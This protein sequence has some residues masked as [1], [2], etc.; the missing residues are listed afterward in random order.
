MTLKQTGSGC[1]LVLSMLLV[2]L[3]AAPTMAQRNKDLPPNSGAEQSGEAKQKQGNGAVGPRK[4][5][6]NQGPDSN[7]RKRGQQGGQNMS[8]RQR[9][10][11]L[12]E[13]FKK[14]DADGDGILLKS[15][16]PQRMQKR[17]DQIDGN[18]DGQLD[19]Q[20]VG[21]LIRQMRE[22]AEQMTGDRKPGQAGNPPG[23]GTDGKTKR[24]PR[25]GPQR[26]RETSEAA[27]NGSVEPIHPGKKNG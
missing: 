9:I 4:R 12:V 23:D 2:L 21:Q 10:Q 25:N 8:P 22:R 27:G 5:D 17:W 13:L 15:E 19:R 16:V 6:A 26:N 1:V 20:E 14:M 18:G 24:G 7:R 11:R 3:M